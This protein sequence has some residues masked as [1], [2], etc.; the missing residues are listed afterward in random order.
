MQCYFDVNVHHLFNI[1]VSNET[2]PGQNLQKKGENKR[3]EHQ[4][5]IL[6]IRIHSLSTKF[7]FKLIILIFGGKFSKVFTD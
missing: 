7:Q 4:H 2:F 6:H 3:N 5:L 1:I